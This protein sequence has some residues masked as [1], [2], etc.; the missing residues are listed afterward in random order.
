MK[1]ILTLLSLVLLSSCSF[2]GMY[3]EPFKLPSNIQ[4]LDLI[5]CADTSIYKFEPETHRPTFLINDQ[6]TVETDYTIE[7][8]MF[9]S[10]N[11]NKLNGC[12]LKSKNGNPT[13]TILHFHGNGGLLVRYFDKIT[14]LIKYGFQVFVF[15]YSGFGFS[16]G[17]ATRENVLIDGNSALTYLQ[18]RDDVKNTKLVIYGQS[19]GGHLSA[20]VAEQRQDEIDGLVVE[21]AFSSHKDVAAEHAWIFGRLLVSEKYSAKE[22]IKNY[23]KPVLIIHSSEDDVIPFE[24]GQTIFNNANAPKELYEIKNCHICGPKFYADSIAYKIK[25]MIK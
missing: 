4:R 8:V 19:L 9:E 1:T 23:K 21:G 7:S 15:D 14:P 10:A 16:E 25:A 20:V 24:M 11:G 3:L 5:S 17:E 22:S 12:L 13:A 6:D 2:N 18:S